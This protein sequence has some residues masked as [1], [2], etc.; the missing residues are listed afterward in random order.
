MT[1][2]RD[3]ADVIGSR[4]TAATADTGL[5]TGNVPTADDLS[6]VGE[7][8]NFT[9]GNLNPNV[10]GGLAAEDTLLVGVGVSATA[11]RFFAPISGLVAP[12][13]LTRVGTFSITTA[14]SLSVATG[15]STPPISSFSG[16]KLLV[17]LV[18]GLSGIVVDATYL[19]RS[20][21]ST[22]KLTVNF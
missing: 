16:N 11:V 22:S 2:P 9:A 8:V 1:Q 12:T 10:F 20:E 21:S 5:L 6:M 19:F 17:S 18:G 4:G 3:T 15:L 14:A 7:T 13:S